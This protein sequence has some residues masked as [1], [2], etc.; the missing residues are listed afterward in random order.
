MLRHLAVTRYNVS[1]D[2]GRD[3]TE[4]KVIAKP[5]PGEDLNDA[6]V[7]ICG[8]FEEI[9]DGH[10]QGGGEPRERIKRRVRCAAFDRAD[11]CL[12]QLGARTQI[13]LA[14]V[15]RAPQRF[16][17]ARERNLQVGLQLTRRSGVGRR[18]LCNVDDGGVAGRP[19]H[20]C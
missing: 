18:G 19:V 14:H 20:H 4:L 13:P 2:C 9:C 10:V 6:R 5:S 12:A 3:M 11:Q 8:L 17:P 1:L 7:P 15:L 16:E